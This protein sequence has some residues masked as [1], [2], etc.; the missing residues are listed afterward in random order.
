M[1]RIRLFLIV[2]TLA[3]LL[4]GCSSK[5]SYRYLDWVIAWALDDYIEWSVDQQ[6]QFDEALAR[7]LRWHQREELP[8]YAAWL[9]QLQ[10]DLAAPLNADQMRAHTDHLNQFW[11]TILEQ[12]FPDAVHLLAQLSDEQVAALLA[13][14]DKQTAQ[15]REDYVE[16]A[17]KERQ[18]GRAKEVRKFARRWLGSLT[19]QQ[20]QLIDAWSTQVLENGEAWMA[21]RQRWRDQL[22]VVL[23]ERAT[24]VFA[25]GLYT[26]FL[27]SNRLWEDDYRAAV[28]HNTGLGVQLLVDLQASLN[29]R[30]RLHLD[31]ELQGWIESFD[32]LAQEAAAAER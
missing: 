8:R 21:A 19:D 25:A 24:P 5:L 13:A 9:R 4:L 2:L 30:Q 31:R 15:Y 29:E 27:E 22:A 14:H 23:G 16:P 10:Q 6:P 12:T 7:Q 17:V 18:R 28:E 26:L 11:R 20:E 3:G 32:E 1:R